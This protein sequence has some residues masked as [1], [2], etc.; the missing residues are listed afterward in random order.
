MAYQRDRAIVLSKEYVRDYDRRYTLYGR[1]HGLITAFARGSSRPTSKHSAHLEPFTD[2][3]VMIANGRHVDHIAV[4][5]QSVGV[6]FCH[7]DS[8]TLCGRFSDVTRKRVRPGVP[9]ARLYDLLTDVLSVAVWCDRM[10]L[11]RQQFMFS[12]GVAKL[13]NYLGHALPFEQ[14]TERDDWKLTEMHIRILRLLRD[15]PLR[16]ALRLTAKRDD[17]ETVSQ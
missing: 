8:Y 1:D 10:S 9:D 3:E 16:D 12:A 14:Q 4:A 13:L 5:K 7:V 15:A 6:R 2:V 11:A 17:L